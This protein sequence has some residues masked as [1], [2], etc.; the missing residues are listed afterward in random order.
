MKAITSLAVT[1]LF[2][3]TI[4]A[5]TMFV[6]FAYA[7]GAETNGASLSPQ[8]WTNSSTGSIQMNVSIDENITANSINLTWFNSTYPAGINI[9]ATNFTIWVNPAFN[10]SV[11]VSEGNGSVNYSFIWKNAT[12]TDFY[13][14]S[15]TKFLYVDNVKP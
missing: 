15:A 4:I 6:S 9:S 7:V 10:G 5:A 13:N 11:T 14:K 3:A 2:L 12:G 1:V 8:N